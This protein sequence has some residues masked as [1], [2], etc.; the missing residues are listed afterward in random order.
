MLQVTHP[1]VLSVPEP[2]EPPPSGHVDADL[3]CRLIRPSDIEP[4]SML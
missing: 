3:E 1:A 4:E 2:I